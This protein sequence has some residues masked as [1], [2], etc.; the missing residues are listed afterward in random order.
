MRLRAPEDEKA[1][2]KDLAGKKVVA[3][4][5]QRDAV[6]VSRRVVRYYSKRPDD[7]ALRQQLRELTTLIGQPGKPPKIVSGVVDS[8]RPPRDGTH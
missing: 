8:L 1:K 3:S 5:T 7:V 6:G 2:L 4:D